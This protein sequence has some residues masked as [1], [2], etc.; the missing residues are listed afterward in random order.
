M[1]TQFKAK[2]TV[3]ITVQEQPVPIQHYLRQPHR[4]ILALV[5][6]KQ[7]EQIQPDVFR[8]K[9]RP[10]KFMM[11]SVQ[12]T[13]DMKIR[14]QS[15]GEIH[16][17]SVAC[18][19]EGV[20][21]IDQRFNLRLKG[22]LSPKMMDNRTHLVGQADLWVEV[23]VPPPLAF[24][25]RSMLETTGNGLLVSVLSTIKQRLMH[26]LLADYRKWAI[27]QQKPVGTT[28]DTLLLSPQRS[29]I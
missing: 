24:T 25:P 11:L 8:L 15:D 2:Q 18:K 3:D 19:I 6:P 7:T 21:F 5:D 9:M 4:V 23:D 16:L 1:H 12:P 10:L 22:I 20:N 27:A 28:P 29:S 26:Q 17:E 14:A 13:V